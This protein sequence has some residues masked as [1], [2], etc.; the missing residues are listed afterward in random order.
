MKF[1]VPCKPLAG[2]SIPGLISRIVQRN[3]YPN[4]GCVAELFGETIINGFSTVNFHNLATGNLNQKLLA[5]YDVT[6][7]SEVRIQVEELQQ[8]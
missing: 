6:I 4:L 8:H 7:S 5:D 1:P 2:E 3:R